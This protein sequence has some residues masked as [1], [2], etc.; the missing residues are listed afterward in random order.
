[1][2]HPEKAGPD[3]PADVLRKE[4]EQR[5]LFM[6]GHDHRVGVNLTTN[7]IDVD[8]AYAYKAA[9]W[10]VPITREDKTQLFKPDPPKDEFWLILV[11]IGRRLLDDGPKVYYFRESAGPDYDTAIRDLWRM[12][13]LGSD[14][15]V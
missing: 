15:E 11:K 9:A 5:M 2:H 8:P 10:L 7:E 1:M 14:V 13:F 12:M 4:I 6:F 3:R